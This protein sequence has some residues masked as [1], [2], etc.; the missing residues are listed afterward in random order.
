MHTST[1]VTRSTEDAVA[2][3]AH[4]NNEMHG[5]FN[6][7]GGN[8]SLIKGFRPLHPPWKRKH[9][10]EAPDEVHLLGLA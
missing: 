5:L 9:V 4:Y 3:Q 6:S 7:R 1:F 8:S 2:Q 10:L